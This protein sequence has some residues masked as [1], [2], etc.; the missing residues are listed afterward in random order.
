[1]KRIVLKRLTLTDFRGQSGTFNFENLNDVKGRNGSGKS[2]IKNAFFWLLMGVDEYN[3]ANYQLFDNR[4]VQTH[5]NSKLAIVEGVF[6]IDGLEYTFK[7]TASMGW[8]RPNGEETYE[9]KGSD[10]YKFY[11]DDI[12]RSATEFKRTIDESF[13][14]IDKLKVMLNVRHYTML[15]WKER[16]KLLEEILKD[17]PLL[18]ID[19]QFPDVSNGIKKYGVDKYKE[20]LQSKLKNVREQTTKLPSEIDGMKSVIPSEDEIT[21]I[22]ERIAEIKDELVKVDE[23]IEGGKESYQRIE[24]TRNAILS[25]IADKENEMYELINN[26]SKSIN[27][28]IN[29]LNSQLL[30]IDV[31]NRES[32]AKKSVYEKKMLD[33]TKERESLLDELSQKESCVERLRQENADLKNL[34]FIDDKCA[35]C[36]NVLPPNM[37]EKNKALFNEKKEAKRQSIIIEGKREVANMER[38]K[39]RL[40]EI[41]NIVDNSIAPTIETIGT[42]DLNDKIVALR[43]QLNNIQESES[44][45]AIKRTIESLRETLPTTSNVDISRALGKRR[46]LE[47][48]LESLVAKNARNSRTTIIEKI[49][50]KNS[51]LKEAC[52]EKATIEGMIA[53]VNRYAETKAR[54]VSD[55]VNS[56]FKVIHVEIEEQDKSGKMIPTCKFTIKGVNDSV[57]N[58]ASVTLAGIDLSNT[59]CKFYELNLPLFVDNAESINEFNL[60][61][62]DRQQITLSVADC[63]LQVV[64]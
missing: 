14:P 10:N 36:G 30:N 13:A 15:D 26:K 2:T 28:K 61:K 60:P 5:E 46:D 54:M 31:Q 55:Q 9:R 42:K 52:A 19:D 43:V 6:D 56:L 40:S 22:E 45:K 18:N 47:N 64:C 12:E 27:E 59:L 44:V 3:R 35:L 57:T 37:L 16:R 17:M 11:I 21:K 7:R 51:E 58:N 53:Q 48:E 50:A 34:V 29:V 8:I 24:S 25:K 38:I 4:V 49:N 39:A 33:L 62:T 1:M 23:E 32:V 63:D 41:K 20:Q